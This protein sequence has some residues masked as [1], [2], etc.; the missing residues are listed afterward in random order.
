V[1]ETLETG[2]MRLAARS[3]AENEGLSVRFTD[4]DPQEKSTKVFIDGL[5]H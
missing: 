5:P 1:G 4:D 3:F 2:L